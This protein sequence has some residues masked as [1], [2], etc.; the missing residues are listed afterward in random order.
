MEIVRVGT[1]NQWSEF[2]SVSMSTI[3]NSGGGSK[4]LS[5]SITT[6]R[7]TT[8]GTDTFDAGSIAVRYWT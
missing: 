4:T 1:T 6:V 3:S 7:V 5:D 8:S 2:H